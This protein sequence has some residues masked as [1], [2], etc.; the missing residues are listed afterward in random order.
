MFVLKKE[1]KKYSHINKKKK[2]SLENS[3]NLVSFGRF[4]YEEYLIPLL[5][6]S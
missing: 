2:K 5:V 4:E 6:S 1:K 3:T